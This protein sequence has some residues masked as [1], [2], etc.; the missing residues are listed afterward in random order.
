VSSTKV[1]CEECEWR[2]WLHEIDRV[3]DPKSDKVWSVCPGCR[4]PE[5]LL[6]ACECEDCWNLVS[7]GMPVASGDYIQVCSNH[8][9]RAG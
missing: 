4:T 8:V 5:N 6:H 3:Q 7:C 1:V 2:G 9:P